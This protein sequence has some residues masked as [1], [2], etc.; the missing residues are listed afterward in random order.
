MFKN[1]GVV[2]IRLG[3]LKGVWQ[4]GM[5]ERL[6]V[7]ELSIRLGILKGVCATIENASRQVGELSIRLGILKVACHHLMKY[8]HWSWRD[9]DPCEGEMR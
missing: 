4:V 5:G 8:F 7:G 6:P 3:I 2:S 9:L 1:V